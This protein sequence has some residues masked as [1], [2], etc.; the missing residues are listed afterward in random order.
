MK[1]GKVEASLGRPPVWTCWIFIGLML[2]VITS[3]AVAQETSTGGPPIGSVAFYAG[4]LSIPANVTDL[5]NKGWLLCDGK[6]YSQS[7]YPALFKAIGHANGGDSTHFNVPDLR[8]RFIRGRNANASGGD[9]DAGSRVAAAPGGAT[10][11]N[12]GSLQHS[13]TALPKTALIVDSAGIHFHKVS[14]LSSTMHEA[15]DGNTYTMAR[16][17]TTASTTEDGLH[18]HPLDGWNTVTIPVNMS[19]YVIIKAKVV[20]DEGGKTPAGV[21]MGIAGE[22]AT[23][24]DWLA[25]N[26]TAYTTTSYPHL[27]QAISSNYGGGQS[28]FNVPDLRGRFLRGT[29]H[30]AGRDPDHATRYASG[31]G[32][33]TGDVTGSAQDYATLVPARNVSSGGAHTHNIGKVPQSDHHAAFGASGP[34]AKNTMMWTNDETESTK[35]GMHHHT[36]IGGDKETRPENVYLDWWMAAS[37]LDSPPPVGS[38]MPIGADLNNLQIAFELYNKGWIPCNGDELPTNNSEYDALYRVIGNAYGGTGRTFN[39]PDLRGYF[40]SGAGGV[41]KAGETTRQSLTGKPMLPIQTSSNG[42]HDHSFNLI[43]ADT[44]E[45][46]AASG[47]DL[48]HSD[49]GPIATSSDGKH[50]HSLTGG[51]KESRPPNVYVDFV[52]RYK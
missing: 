41:K 29:D 51:D 46:D 21:I 31:P 32:G 33:E 43:P 10:G 14:H 7:A 12:V 24:S 28:T 17:N 45:I 36:V 23:V 18:F 20:S 44:H 16:Y 40:V 5:E 22:L 52:I 4:D 9:P 1:T 34:L 38:I 2:T 19:L 15:Y 50:T 42:V 47:W 49:P 6:S 26:G 13:A 3:G 11:N 30:T 48:A 27:Y 8:D 39:V 37:D 35:N 25:C